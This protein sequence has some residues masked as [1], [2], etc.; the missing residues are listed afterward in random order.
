[1]S[2]WV[3]HGGNMSW[4]SLVQQSL[5]LERHQRPHTETRLRRTVHCVSHDHYA[6]LAS[7]G[8]LTNND[9]AAAAELAALY[10]SPRHSITLLQKINNILLGARQGY[11]ERP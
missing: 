9:T 10:G 3:V 8:K 7:T 2:W 6:S 5:L 1:M 11:V 4:T